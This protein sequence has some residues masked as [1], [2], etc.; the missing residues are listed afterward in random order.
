MCLARC[1][2]L[3]HEHLWHIFGAEEGLRK[4]NI[5]A[6]ML[7]I[8]LGNVWVYNHFFFFKTKR[9]SLHNKMQNKIIS[10]ILFILSY[11]TCNKLHV[12]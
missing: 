2:N 5:A 3:V 6:Q 8:S 4:M 12:E 10:T 1:Q 7:L 9:S 11:L